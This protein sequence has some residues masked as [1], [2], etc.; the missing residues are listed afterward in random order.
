[1]NVFTTTAYHLFKLP[2]NT[3]NM[4][5]DKRAKF[6]EFNKL[7]LQ[8]PA[9]VTII[10]DGQHHLKKFKVVDGQMKYQ[11]AQENNLPFKFVI[12]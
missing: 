4:L 2:K 11:Y 3:R 7:A 12:K 6:A 1:M 5:Y 10:E 9:I 8:S